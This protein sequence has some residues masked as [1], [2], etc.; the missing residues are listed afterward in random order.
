VD[1]TYGDDVLAL[2]IAVGFLSKLVSNQK[3]ERHLSQH[4]AE[5]LG[6]FRSI[7][8]AASLDSESAAAA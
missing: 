8:S 6:Q 7:I 1:A 3:V 4:H 2:V 5:I